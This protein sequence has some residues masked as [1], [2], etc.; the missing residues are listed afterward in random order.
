MLSG[1][2][3]Q[4]K[5][6][7]SV[8]LDSSNTERLLDNIGQRRHS[9][10]QEPALED[11]GL[12]SGFSGN[13][14][15]ARTVVGLHDGTEEALARDASDRQKFRL[16]LAVCHIRNA[17]HGRSGIFVESR[18]GLCLFNLYHN[19]WWR[20]IFA[21]VCLLQLGLAVFEGPTTNTSS[22]AAFEAPAYAI[23]SAEFSC[24]AFLLADIIIHCASR[25]FRVKGCKY[26]W[27]TMARLV[28][29][30]LLAADWGAYGLVL[31][32]YQDGSYIYPRYTR[33]LR[34]LF[35]VFRFRKIRTVF[36][37]AFEWRGP[38]II[39][40]LLMTTSVVAFGAF[41]Y[42]LFEDPDVTTS[43]RYFHTFSASLYNVLLVCTSNSFLLQLQA[44]YLQRW[45][46]F[47]VLY[48]LQFTQRLP[49]LL[50]LTRRLCFGRQ[51]VCL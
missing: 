21:I 28:L 23:V 9:G 10:D 8:L 51:T 5:D 39:T 41:G 25:P 34:P 7:F 22:F 43:N 37:G 16:R 24:L 46:M 42:L 6:A 3:S 26:C 19:R 30:I 33:A 31:M 18:R 2:R 15:P 35:I 48:V 32:K 38:T 40:F 12:S 36:R 29:V 49:P 1:G 45:S 50:S 14:P 44:P 11:D 47:A 20:L 27:W 13:R 4:E 17:V